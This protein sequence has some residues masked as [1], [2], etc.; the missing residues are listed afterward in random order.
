VVAARG[1]RVGA[2]AGRLRHD[3]V[4]AAEVVRHLDQTVEVD[5]HV[6]V[7]AHLGELLDRLDEQRRAAE[8]VAGV[9]LVAAVP[10]DVDPGVARDRDQLCVLAVGAEAGEHDR[11]G[12][13]IRRLAR[14]EL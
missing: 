6:V 4:D 7:D 10:G 3:D 11:V 9:D 2:V 14:R 12:A 1:E 13:A 5:G 8:G